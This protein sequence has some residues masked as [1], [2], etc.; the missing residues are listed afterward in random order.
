MAAPSE[1]VMSNAAISASTVDR[2]IPHVGASLLATV[3]AV[4]HTSASITSAPV[5]MTGAY[6]KEWSSLVSVSIVRITSLSLSAGQGVV[7]FLRLVAVVDGHG[8]CDVGVV[9]ADVGG[10]ERVPPRV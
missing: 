2:G 10:K 5:Q 6:G 1:M 4:V 7:L 9:L 8:A 3:T